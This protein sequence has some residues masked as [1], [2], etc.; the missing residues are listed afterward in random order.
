MCL[1]PSVMASAEAL[2]SRNIS[3]SS[4]KNNGEKKPVT[5]VNPSTSQAKQDQTKSQAQDNPQQDTNNYVSII[6]M[7]QS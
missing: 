6:K 3:S 7:M 1:F 4:P 2:F 5:I